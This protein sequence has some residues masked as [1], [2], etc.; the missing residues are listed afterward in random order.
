VKLAI[1]GS[2]VGPFSIGSLVLTGATG[3]GLVLAGRPKLGR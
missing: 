2:S 3:V 1:D